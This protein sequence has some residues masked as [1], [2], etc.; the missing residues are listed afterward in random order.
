MIFSAS[1][2][3]RPRPGYVVK[4]R[5]RWPGYLCFIGVNLRIMACI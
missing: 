1:R 5:I 4:T 2:D 3:I